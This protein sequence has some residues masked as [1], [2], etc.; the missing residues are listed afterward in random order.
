ML[1]G[2]TETVYLHAPQ[3]GTWNDGAW[4]EVSL[5][6]DM[7]T[8]PTQITSAFDGSTHTDSAHLT[9]ARGPISVQYGLQKGG[10]APAADIEIDDVLV[11]GD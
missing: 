2:G 7:S 5:T 1:L 9:W 4:H 10:A 3:A 6:L 11:V 8:S